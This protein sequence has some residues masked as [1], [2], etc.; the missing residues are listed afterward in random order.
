MERYTYRKYG[1]DNFSFSILYTFHSKS[2]D[3][4]T[5]LLDAMETF[6]IRKF[7][8]YNNSTLGGHS[9]RGYTFSEEFKEKCRNRRHSLETRRK[10]SISVHNRV[11]SETTKEKLRSIAVSN[12][13]YKYI[14]P[15]KDKATSNRRKAITK[16]V[17]QLDKNGVLIKEWESLTDASKSLK[18]DKSPISKCC[19]KLRKT[20]GG[21]M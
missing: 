13:S 4:L 12:N 15:F 17:I 2:L 20:A 6:L 9:K 11:V 8:S 1:F 14:E 3:R 21:Y 18:I 16:P 7:D 19:S 10:M 5:I